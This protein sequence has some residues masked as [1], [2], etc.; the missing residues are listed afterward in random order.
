MTSNIQ[1]TIVVT[2]GSKGIGRAICAAF[3]APGVAVYFNFHSDADAGRTTSELIREAGGV[4]RGMRA[5]VRRESEISDFLKT[6]VDETGRIDVLVN[7]AAMTRDGLLLRMKT[8]DWD[9][10][11][12]VNLTGTFICTKIAAKTMLKQRAGRIVNITSVAGVAGNPG[13]S[14]YAASKAGIIGF[15]K[16]V[17][18]ELASR[19]ITVNAVAP[20]FIKTDMTATLSEQAVT[21]IVSRIPL[22]RAGT[23]EDV[24]GVVVFL[25]SPQADYITGQ[26][27]HV[28]G[29][30]YL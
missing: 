6:V 3:A 4:P 1:R 26:V 25:A 30:M 5:D 23:P 8:A 12:Q 2:G 11:M 13:Q 7:N 22:A 21:D 9:E 20:G 29:G 28:N 24:A 18:R 27:I 17:A 19:G 10:V 15:T 14:N 16:T